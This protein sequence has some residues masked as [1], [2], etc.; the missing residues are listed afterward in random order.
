MLIVG[1]VH[2][3]SPPKP[4]VHLPTPAAAQSTAR[5]LPVATSPFSS[6]ASNLP[7]RLSQLSPLDISFVDDRFGWFLGYSS[8]GSG[9]GQLELRSTDDAGSYWTVLPAPSTV[10]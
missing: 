1:C 3:S 5:A 2:L 7:A 4:P 9:H 6:P 10:P 8:A